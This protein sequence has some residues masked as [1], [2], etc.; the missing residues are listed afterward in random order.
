LAPCRFVRG[1]GI[2]REATQRRLRSPRSRGAFLLTA[3]RPSIVRRVRQ[4]HALEHATIHV[5]SGLRQGAC[6]AGRSDRNGFVIY[7]DLD[8]SALALAA[9]RALRRLQHGEAQLAVHPRC[10]TNLASGIVAAALLGRVA[11]LLFRPRVPRWIAVVLAASTGLALSRRLGQHVQEHVTTLCDVED[12]HIA[13]I[14]EDRVG[15]LVRHRVLVRHA[16]EST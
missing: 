3:Y 13:G 15:G 16:G 2:S 14:E 6:V 9:D 10:G 8:M 11:A 12:A 5:L 1:T 4:N 7:G